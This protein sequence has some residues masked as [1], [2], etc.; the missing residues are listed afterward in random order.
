MGACHGKLPGGTSH[1]SN[2]LSRDL[3]GEAHSRN[4][5]RPKGKALERT[6]PRLCAS[7]DSSDGISPVPQLETMRNKVETGSDKEE[8][9]RDPDNCVMPRDSEAQQL[10]AEELVER[11]RKQSN[12]LLD[13]MNNLKQVKVRQGV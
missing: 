11:Y 2:S 4:G 9:A 3:Q 12:A 10:S 8:I 5:F 6:G 13:T 1:G 7:E